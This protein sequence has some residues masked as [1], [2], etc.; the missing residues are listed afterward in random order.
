MNVRFVILKKN[1][2]LKKGKHFTVLLARAPYTPDHLLIVPNRH[3]VRLWEITMEEWWTLV[4][5]IEKWTKNLEKIHKEVN[6]LLRDG[7]ANGVIWKS[8]DHLHFHLAPDC[9]IYS[10]SWGWNRKIYSDYALAKEVKDL[11]KRLDMK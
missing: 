11:K 2:L 10:W 6:I 1:I 5:L 4:P 8:I 3:L 7:V 9:L